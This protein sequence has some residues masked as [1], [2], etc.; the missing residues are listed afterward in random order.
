MYFVRDLVVIIILS[1]LTACGGGGGGGGSDAGKNNGTGGGNSSGGNSDPEPDPT[2]NSTPTAS[3]VTVVDGNGAT[4]VVSDVLNATYNYNDVDGD[5]EGVSA[6]QWLRNGSA[7]SGA[8]SPSYTLTA[9][10]SGH[11]IT[12]IVTPIASAGVNNSEPVSSAE[13]VVVNSSPI[14]SDV[15]ITDTNGGDAI[16]GDTLTGHYLY[17]DVDGDTEG[18][19]IFRWLRNNVVIEGANALNYILTTEDAGQPVTLEVTPIA[20]SGN[21]T[22]TAVTS[23]AL[24]SRLPLEVTAPEAQIIFPPVLSLTY[25]EVV[26]VHGTAA[27][28]S[29]IDSVIVNGINATSTDNFA[30]WEATVPL[31]VGLNSIDVTVKDK[32]TNTTAIDASIRRTH[33]VTLSGEMALSNDG[34]KLYVAS[35]DDEIFVVDRI[36]GYAQL[37]SGSGV[38]D[39]VNPLNNISDIRLDEANHRLLVADEQGGNSSL[40]ALSLDT[41]ARD[42]LFLDAIERSGPVALYHRGLAKHLT[43]S[44]KIYLLERVIP[45][46]IPFLHI[47]YSVDLKTGTRT[48]LSSASAVGAGP[49][50]GLPRGLANHPADANLALV[51]N[52]SEVLLVNTLTGDRSYLSGGGVGAGPDF[53]YIGAIGHFPNDISKVLVFDSNANTLYAVALDSGDRTVIS[54]ATTGTG[55]VFSGLGQSIS[56]HPTDNNQVL[57]LDTHQERIFAV[58][59]DTGNRRVISGQSVGFGPDMISPAGIATTPGSDLVWLIDSTQGVYT[60]NLNNGDRVF[61]S[62]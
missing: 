17:S 50:F 58:E 51:V 32:E 56:S 36:D 11:A 10:D 7:I 28:A 27:D 52:S 29:G 20:S 31:V 48:V 43:D 13:M 44:N 19:P 16:I 23:S 9:A 55:P 3:N 61:L 62:R 22:G 39:A 1:V 14:A 6:F 46:T 12:F 4:T 40:K 45:P 24:T 54:D 26:N 34:L 53:D 35:N 41:G 2:P 37:F 47:L 8:T 60:V 38:P 21:V 57:V 33:Q 49:G 30:H 42:L 59:L 25:Q 5:A 15:N 18:S